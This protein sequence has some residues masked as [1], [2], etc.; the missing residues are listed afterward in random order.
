[1]NIEE[2]LTAVENALIWFL[3][4]GTALATVDPDSTTFRKLLAAIEAAREGCDHKW[5][6]SANRPDI[7]YCPKCETYKDT[8]TKAAREGEDDP[9][10][11]D[12]F[13]VFWDRY[14]QA[15]WPSNKLNAK[16]RVTAKATWKAAMAA[17]EGED[18]TEDSSCKKYLDGE[19]ERGTR[20][21][22]VGDFRDG[23]MARAKQSAPSPR[24]ASR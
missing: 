16:H 17:R 21:T 22:Y 14:N 18:A 3:K 4:S 11:D 24:N 20:R 1:M 8:P 10:I 13:A 9:R 7:E 23:W 2:R 6:P 15:R 5:K 19:R 12:S